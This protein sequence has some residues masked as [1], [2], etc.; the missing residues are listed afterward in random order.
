MSLLDR[1]VQFH[2]L[3]KVQAAGAFTNWHSLF[4]HESNQTRFKDD[5]SHNREAADG[6]KA[7]VT[8]EYARAAATLNQDL[9]AAHYC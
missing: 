9:V 4:F 8:S 2:Q 6:L 1:K 5:I 3:K 7:S